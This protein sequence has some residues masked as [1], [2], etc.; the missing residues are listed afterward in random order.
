[1]SSLP[2]EA[3]VA[4]AI[5]VPALILEIISL[6]LQYTRASNEQQRRRRDLDLQEPGY[7]LFQRPRVSNH[8]QN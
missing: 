3:V 6:W 5:G 7:D 8:H 1:M 2:P 4:L